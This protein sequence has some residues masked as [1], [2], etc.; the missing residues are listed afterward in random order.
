MAASIKIPTVFTANDKFSGV[1]KEMTKANGNFSASLQRIGKRADNMSRNLAIGGGAIVGVFGVAVNSASK[2]E[3]K[4][5]DV[6]KTTGLSGEGLDN[7]GKDILSMSKKTRS[8]IEDIQQIAVIGGQL[9]VAKDELLGFT[10]AGNKFSVALA[11]DYSGGVESAVLSV[12]KLNSLFTDTQAL[13]IDEH[14]NRAGSAFNQ[15]SSEGKSSVENIN[16]F[17]SRVGTLPSVL[18]PSFTATAGLGAFLEEVGINSERGASGFSTLIL[19]AGKELPKFARQMGL[20]TDAARELLEQDPVKFAQKFSRSLNGLRPDE[21]ASRLK[22]LKI[23]GQ[24]SIKVVGALGDETNRL[25]DLMDSSSQAFKS[26]TSLTDEYNVKNETTAAK[27]AMAKNNMEALSITVG[28]KVAPILSKLIDIVI[29]LI[30][31]FGKWADDNPTLIKGIA[32][33]G[34]GMLTLAGITKGVAIA[35]NVY[36]AAQWLLN[37]A[38]NANPIGLIIIGIAALIGL[39]ALIIAKYDEWGAAL[40]LLLGPFGFIINLIQSF[41]R[42]WDMI[43]KSFSEGGIVAG[44]KAI[45]ITILDALLMP[46]QQFLELVAKIPGMGG[47]AGSGIAIIERMREN[48]GVSENDP[49]TLP[50]TTQASNENVSRSITENNSNVKLDIV[51]KGGNV[52]NVSQDGNIPINLTNTA[53]AN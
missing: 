9:G 22:Q 26:A 42:N 47:I 23:G 5:A 27:I 43:K 35:V 2:F 18:K 30:D 1:V 39:V 28:T 14:L 29:P 32:L 21:L 41:R 8:S 13:K 11:G 49:E 44:L 48:L 52:G 36:T 15:L 45:G 31:R 34:L 16:D 51:D 12:G 6:A 53:G 25:T 40:S 46:M 19:T 17:A 20:G 33:L 50:S 38:L 3:D 37:I 4:M 24:E 10:E 7:L